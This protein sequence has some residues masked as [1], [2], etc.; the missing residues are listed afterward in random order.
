[1]PCLKD[2]NGTDLY[3]KRKHFSELKIELPIHVIDQYL[4][5]IESS[6]SSLK[7]VGFLVVGS[8]FSL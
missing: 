3:Y 7:P 8:Y 4:L 5:V 2:V 1:M 6:L